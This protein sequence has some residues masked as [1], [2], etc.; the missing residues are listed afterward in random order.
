MIV[1]IIQLVLKMPAARASCLALFA[2]CALGL[3]AGSWASS[4]FVNAR[5][6]N[7]DAAASYAMMFYIG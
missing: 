1:A 3:C 7:A 6:L 4:Y 5:G 2:S